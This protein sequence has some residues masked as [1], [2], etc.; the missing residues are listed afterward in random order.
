MVDCVRYVKTTAVSFFHDQKARREVASLMVPQVASPPDTT[1]M[2]RFDIH[3]IDSVYGRNSDLYRDILGVSPRS[4]RKEIR[5]AFVDSRDAFFSFQSQV[6][7]GNVVVTDGQMDFAK[8]R[9]DA[10]V[11][12]FRILHDPDLRAY[13]D[14]TRVKRLHQR[15]VHLPNN[16]T[17][18]PVV[19]AVY[20][21]LEKPRKS[22]R[23]STRSPLESSSGASTPESFRELDETRNSPSPKSKRRARDE[24]SK[25]Y[26][27]E[28]PRPHKSNS[29]K[30][31]SS[32]SESIPGDDIGSSR[33]Y[34]RDE[35]AKSSSTDTMSTV[36]TVDDGVGD[37]DSF[38]DGSNTLMDEN[39]LYEIEVDDGT[40]DEHT[41]GTTYFY[42]EEEELSTLCGC[43]E[44]QRIQTRLNDNSLAAQSR[45]IFVAV[46]SEIKGTIHDTISA[47]DQVCNAF[48]LQER[49]I[50]AVTR[51]IDK[52]SKQ[53]AG[54]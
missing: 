12:A 14:E 11:A 20:K 3:V 18:D 40:I 53:L 34:Y 17:D 50:E 44:E 9:M 22:R 27:V 48:T 30:S 45:A 4:S 2:N 1:A 38:H 6:E 39:E 52:A 33:N 47:I 25:F 13:Y 51:K 10:V 21:A 54:P 49:D 5:A 19:Q 28:R 15:G 24:R 7:D 41:L 46:R 26:M 31:L 37:G 23:S 32:D 36:A 29:A 16:N 35:H 8:K 42:D 43:S